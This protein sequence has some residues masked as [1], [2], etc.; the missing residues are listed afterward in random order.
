MDEQVLKDPTIYPDSPIV[1]SIYPFDHT[2]HQITNFESV[3][4]MIANYFVT[5]AWYVYK[6]DTSL[7]N[8]GYYAQEHGYPSVYN[9]GK[10]TKMISK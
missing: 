3:E 9:N 6:N 8:A 7:A 2:G 5:S 10:A 1:R 4:D